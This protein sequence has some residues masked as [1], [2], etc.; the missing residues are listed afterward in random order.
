[1]KGGEGRE[2]TLEVSSYR[3]GKRGKEP[4]RRGG[5]NRS[6]S[7]EKERKARER[8]EK[9]KKGIRHKIRNCWLK[10]LLIDIFAS[11]IGFCSPDNSA[12]EGIRIVMEQLNKQVIFLNILL[13]RVQKNF[14]WMSWC[15]HVNNF[16]D[17]QI[18]ILVIYNKIRK[19]N[20]SSPIVLQKFLVNL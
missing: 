9:T 2:S 20:L 16:V 15:I 13:Q 17:V 4:M 19:L 11:K 7:G 1:M 8:N 10:A 5:K 18:N 12:H 3:R 14:P 6:K